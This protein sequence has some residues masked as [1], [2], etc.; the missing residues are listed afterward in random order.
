MTF[1]SCCH[2]VTPLLYFEAVIRENIKDGAI[3]LSCKIASVCCVLLFL[4]FSK[5]RKYFK[6]DLLS[7]GHVIPKKNTLSFHTTF[8][9]LL[10]SDNRRNDSQLHRGSS[11]WV[12]AI[13][14]FMRI[15]WS[16]G[17]QWSHFIK[18]KGTHLL[19]LCQDDHFL[20]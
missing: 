18:N 10:M 3:Y 1:C 5:N 7:L 12:S 11:V 20:G 17:K 16:V 4:S 2:R 14:S 13:C 19:L 6:L 15:G 9:M 8:S